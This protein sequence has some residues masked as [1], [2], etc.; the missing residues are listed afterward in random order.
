MATVV[1]RTTPACHTKVVQ[2]RHAATELPQTETTLVLWA[3][4]TVAYLQGLSQDWETTTSLV[5]SKSRVAPLKKMTLPR[6][7]LM[8]AVIGARL[9]NNLMSTLKM[10]QKSIKMWTDMMNVLH[11]ICSSAQKRKPFVANGVTELQSL[12]DPESS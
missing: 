12:T 1:F 2:S 8:V 3:Y 10:E 11:W 7:E 9:A 5:A 4:S 6:L